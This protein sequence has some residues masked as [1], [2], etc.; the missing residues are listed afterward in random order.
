MLT[1]N[2][3][4]CAGMDGRVSPRRIARLIG[5]HGPDIVALQEIDLGRRRSRAEDQAAIIARTLGMHAAFCPTVSK[6]GEH[7]G[8]ALLSR[9]PVEVVKRAFLPP[10]PAA[11]GRN[12]ARAMWVRVVIG[13]RRL[14][15]IT[16]H[17]GLGTRGAPAPNAGTHGPGV[18][19]CRSGG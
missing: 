2:V 4:G 5:N 1:Y 17:L 12:R 3:H 6:D 13:A 19:W 16:T 8:H 7:Y 15:V 9:W 18:A 11:G 10:P 14:N